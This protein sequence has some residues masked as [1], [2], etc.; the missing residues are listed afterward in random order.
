MQS[1]SVELYK[2]S[3]TLGDLSKVLELC[4]YD[5]ENQHLK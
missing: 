3:D 1:S 5:E 2:D 4:I